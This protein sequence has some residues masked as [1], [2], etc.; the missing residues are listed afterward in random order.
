[1]PGWPRPVT[2]PQGYRLRTN[3]LAAELLNAMA[4]VRILRISYKGVALAMNDVIAGRL[5]VFFMFVKKA[6]LPTIRKQL[7]IYERLKLLLD[8]WIDLATEL[9]NLR[10]AKEKN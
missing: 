8:R 3:H 2:T 5:Q 10:I 6:D 9:S 4:G 1:M 7:K